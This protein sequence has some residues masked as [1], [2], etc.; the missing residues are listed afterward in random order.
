MKNLGTDC[1]TYPEAAITFGRSVKRI[2]NLMYAHRLEVLYG[3]IGSHPRRHVF[4]P[5]STLR[6]LRGLLPQPLAHPT[7]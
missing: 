6:D 4:L 1:L 5:A 3:R 7:R 2:Q